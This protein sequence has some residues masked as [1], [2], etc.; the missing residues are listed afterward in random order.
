MLWQAWRNWRWLPAV[1]RAAT[2]L[3]ALVVL[4]IAIGA[5]AV[6]TGL[7][8]HARGAHVAGAAAVW[9]AAVALTCLVARGRR[10]APLPIEP[11]APG[12]LAPSEDGP[13]PAAA[14]D[15][16]VPAP[17]VDGREPVPSPNLLAA[18]VSLTKPRIIVLLLVTTLPP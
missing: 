3:A 5:V 17:A 16:R 11:D 7:S 15:G 14:E 10:L 12:E 18:Y 1:P 6:S 13:V 9:A 2:I 4:Q 8:A